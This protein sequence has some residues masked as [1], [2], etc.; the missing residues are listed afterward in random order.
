MQ[1]QRA[2]G[3]GRGRD[4]LGFVE[5]E[6]THGEMEDGWV[7]NGDYGFLRKT[8]ERWWYAFFLLVP[9]SLGLHCAKMG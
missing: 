1:A 2:R 8:R 6:S 9:T 5:K 4:R 7:G 3:R